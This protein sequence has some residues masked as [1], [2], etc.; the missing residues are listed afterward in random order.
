MKKILI[1]G[2][3]GFVGRRF[4]KRLRDSGYEVHCVDPV[5]P[6]TGGI[7]PAIGWPLFSP[8]DYAGFHF[9]RQDCRR[10]FDSRSDDDF[11]YVF[12]L[13]AMVGGRAMIENR[14]LAVA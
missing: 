3:A 14:P 11:D 10:W 12:H 7:D 13:A 9:Y 5:A 8:E 2:G 1:T 6:D 4:C